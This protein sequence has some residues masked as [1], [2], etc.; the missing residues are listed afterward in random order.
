MK[1]PA[2]KDIRNLRTNDDRDEPIQ[3]VKTNNDN[4]LDRD[5]NREVSRERESFLRR[6]DTSFPLSGGESDEDLDWVLRDQYEPAEFVKRP[7]K[8]IELLPKEAWELK[9]GEEE[10]YRLNDGE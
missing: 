6:I 7:V 5:D 10:D 1:N 8:T 3:P 2:R 9:A 4:D